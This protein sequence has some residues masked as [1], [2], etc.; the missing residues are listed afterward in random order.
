MRL[1]ANRKNEQRVRKNSMPKLHEVI[2][3]TKTKSE[4][5]SGMQRGIDPFPVVITVTNISVEHKKEVGRVAQS[6]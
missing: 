4:L 6:V 5:C 2:G 1:G 3:G